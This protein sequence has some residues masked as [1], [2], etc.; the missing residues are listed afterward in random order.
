GDD[1]RCGSRGHQRSS[2]RHHPSTHDHDLLLLKVGSICYLMVA[3]AASC[4]STASG[5]RSWFITTLPLA[6][7]IAC[8]SLSAQTCSNA[9]TPALELGS[10]KLPTSS[11]SL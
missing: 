1:C 2:T 11:M 6:L 3:I 7:A 9:N 10:S 4:S 8:A 5:M